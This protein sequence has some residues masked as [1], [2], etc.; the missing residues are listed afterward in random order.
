MIENVN[1][2]PSRDMFEAR[3]LTCKSP[4]LF[5]IDIKQFQS[6]VL[7][8]GDEGGCHVLSSFFT[9]LS[10]FAAAHEMEVFH[11]CDDTFILLIDIPFELTKME[12]LIGALSCAMENLSTTYAHQTITY[13]VHI[14]ISFDHFDALEKA[15]KALLVAKAENQLFVTYSEFANVLMNENEEAIETMMKTA[16]EEGQIVLHFQSILDKKDQPFCYEALLRLAYHQTLQSPKL[17]LK[18]AKKRHFYDLLLHSITKKAVELASAKNIV[19]ALNLSSE[20]LIDNE[21]IAFFE[22]ELKNKPIILEIEYQ[23]KTP[24]SL[25]KN[26]I[27]KLKESHIFIALDNVQESELL[28]HFD[29]GMLDSIKVH[30]NLIRNLCVDEHAL[31]TCKKILE[32]CQTKKIKTVATHI[33]SNATLETVHALAFDFFQGYI[34]DQPHALD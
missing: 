26:A 29:E 28:H 17:F 7:G 11:L 23:P 8:Y 31:F 5:L 3:I 6:I 22:K 4:K 10:S 15:Q 30:G 19:I 24:I 12:N 16:I 27:A 32:I 1:H 33:N 25:F 18:I 2:F 13:T 34:I 9:T 14:G 20:Y 21:R